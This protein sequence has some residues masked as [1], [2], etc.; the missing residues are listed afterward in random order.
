MVEHQTAIHN[1]MKKV[2]CKPAQRDRYPAEMKNVW[3]MKQGPYD[4]GTEK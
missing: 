4:T 3:C 2:K 1:L